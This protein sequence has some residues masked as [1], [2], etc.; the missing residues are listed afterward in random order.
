MNFHNIIKAYRFDWKRIAKNPVA[1]IILIGLSIIPSLYGWVNIKACWD[2]YGNTATIPVAV[3]NNDKDAHFRNETVNVGDKIIKK[4]EKNNKIKWVFTTSEDANMGLIDSTYYAMIEIPSDFS[5]RFVSILSD[6]PQKPEI[7]FKVDTKANPVAGKIT[8][9]ASNTLVQ[10]IS[11]E[12]ISTVNETAFSSLNIVGK[13][14]KENREN[15]IKLKDAVININSNMGIVTSSLKSVE[16]NSNNLN[17]F[18]ETF[19]ASMPYIQSGLD[20][21]GKSNEDNQKILSSMQKSIDDSA[22]NIDFNLNYIQTSNVKIKDLFNSLNDSASAGNASK[23]DTVLPVI[24]TQLRSMNSSLDATIEYL[25]Q[26]GDY[27]YNSD[28]DS[29]ITALTKLKTQLTSLRKTLTDFQSKLKDASV[30]LDKLSDY[31]QTEIPKIQQRIEELDQ[32]LTEAIKQLKDLNKTLNSPELAR[33]IDALEKIQQSDLK[34]K[35]ISVLGS[36]KD[37]IPQL[38]LSVKALSQNI[39]DMVKDIDSVN[40]KIEGTVTFLQSVKTQSSVKKRQLNKMITSLENTKPYITDQQNQLGNIRSQLQSANNITRETAD[41]VN[42]DMN[43]ISSQINNASLAYHSGVQKELGNM[44]NNMMATM[45]TSS[46]LIKNAQDLSA[47][48]SVMLKTAQQGTAMTAEFSK[49]LNDKLVEFKDVVSSLGSKFEMVNNS[50]IAEII[51]ILQNDPKLMGEYVSN[52]FEIKEQSINK[53]P[54]Y[55]SGMAPIYTTLALWVGCLVLNSVL[56][57]KSLYK[58][59]ALNLTLQEEHF[60][61]MLFFATLSI[62]QGLIVSIGDIALL[63]IYV[64]NPALFIFFGVYSSLVFCII[65]FT[66]VSTMGNVGKAL[67]IIYLILQVAGS[68]GSYPIQVDPLIFRILQPLFPFTYT[69][70]GLR[71]AIAGPLASSV[72]VDFIGLTIF[73]LL[74]LIGGYL[75]VKPLNNTLRQFE[76]NFKKSGLG[77]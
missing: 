41:I 26:C 64:V 30:S 63:K 4:L 70:G 55:G 7:I 49:A 42:N 76:L 50:D 68:G 21:V 35:L 31:L 51:N 24:S 45:Q 5:S 74:F 17:K 3:V 18:L 20:A 37:E 57:T 10:Q 46:V 43:K 62:L 58:Y 2:V 28:V 66:L 15:I 48:I 19:S 22:A 38:Q 36:I 73:A 14:A 29:A 13:N 44:A 39:D 67:S 16:S 65:T 71:E 72:I 69:L 8:A 23:I 53:I 61:K 52:P 77:E 56:S 59:E 54:N 6:K 1:I 33:L 27:D 12:F 40:K 32:S 9:T 47:Q 75:T 34:D 60:S 11:Q 25:K